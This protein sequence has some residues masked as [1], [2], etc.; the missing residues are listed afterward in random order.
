MDLA[1]RASRQ[2]NEDDVRGS[3]PTA[4]LEDQEEAIIPTMKGWL[5]MAKKNIR[6][7]MSAGTTKWGPSERH[8]PSRNRNANPRHAR[9]SR[10]PSQNSITLA[11][12]LF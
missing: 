7:T 10:R 8:P 6:R 12:P 9:G 3:I 2:A 5:P 4:L 1:K 11:R